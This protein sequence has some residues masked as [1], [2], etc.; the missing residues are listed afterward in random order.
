MSKKQFTVEKSVFNT[1]FVVMQQG[2][3]A[4]RGKKYQLRIM[5]IPISGPS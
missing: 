3:D 5:V 2:V 4:L 1:E